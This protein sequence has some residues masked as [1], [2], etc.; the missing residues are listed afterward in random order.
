M[1]KF[2]I[3]ALCVGLAGMAFVVTGCGKKTAEK[4]AET[5]AEKAIEKA[6]NGQA[7]VDLGTNSVRININGGSYQVGGDIKLPSGF[8]SDVYVI[9]GTIKAA[10]TVKEGETYTVTIETDESMA[11]VK[12][13]YQSK[14][15]GDG[16]SITATM[17]V[18][19]TSFITAEKGSRKVS[20]SIGTSEGK[21]NVVLGTSKTEE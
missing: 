18:A 16:W 4:V 11:S 1:K 8:P 10:T 20:V 21:T 5:A 15:E 12:E 17:D 13:K 2:Y 19:G 6:T 9:D 7:Q 3:F 14:L